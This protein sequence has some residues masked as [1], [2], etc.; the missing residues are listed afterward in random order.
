MPTEDV[1][2]DWTRQAWSGGDATRFAT[3]IVMVS[4]LLCEAADVRAGQ[5]VLDIAAGTGN[6]ALAAARRNCIAV[7]LDYVPALLTSARRRAM[8]DSL[9]L[10]AVGAD[11]QSLPFGDGSFDVVLSTFG[12]MFVP[13]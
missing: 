8:A 13:D 5:R 10:L 1:A 6:S 4:E 9:P 3:T 7:A 12:L 11:A 2:R